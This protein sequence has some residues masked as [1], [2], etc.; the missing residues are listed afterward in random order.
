MILISVLYPLWVDYFGMLLALG[1]HPEVLPM[2]TK[3]E[4]ECQV[5]S[6]KLL[7]AQAVAGARGTSNDD[8][9]D[10]TELETEQSTRRQAELALLEKLY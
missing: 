3:A 10:R 4:L 9:A 1:L 2:P 6:L 7:L 8:E 5:K